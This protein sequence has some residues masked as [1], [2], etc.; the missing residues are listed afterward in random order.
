M[1]IIRLMVVG[2]VVLAAGVAHA[3]MFH[4][5]LSSGTAQFPGKTAAAFGQSVD[6]TDIDLSAGVPH[7][8][9]VN[10]FT[11]FITT[12]VF[13]YSPGASV[14]FTQTF[15][16]NDVPT[17][18]TRTL[19]L[20]QA[21]NDHCSLLQSLS[22]LRMTVDL[23]NSGRVTIDLST[24][25]TLAIHCTNGVPDGPVFTVIPGTT[26]SL[27]A[28]VLAAFT[29]YKVKPTKGTTKLAPFGP[30]SLND[31][32]GGGDYDVTALV[33]L[34]APA[35]VN[36]AGTFDPAT[37]LARYALKRRKAFGKF[38]KIVDLPLTS[39][40]GG[41]VVTVTKPESLLVPVNKS[42]TASPP[43]VP[44]P[45]V[46][47]VDHFLCYAAKTQK[48]RSDG[49]LAATLP[50]KMQLTAADQFETR[51]YDVKKLTRLCLPVDKSG[52]PAVL[53]T[54]DPVPI[55][56]ASI[57]NPASHLVC[58]QVKPAKVTI[59][60][61][62]CGPVDPKDKGTK[63]DPPPAKHQ[64]VSVVVNGQLGAASLDT[65]KEL[66]LCVPLAA[67]FGT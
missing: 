43:A 23:G 33:A 28:S 22:P 53:K 4:V 8:F 14:T 37:H 7:D 16:V 17:T 63:I 60:Q 30:L 50:K 40:C 11:N 12:D 52:S 39:E 1:R 62:S 61:T 64:P 66:E 45:Q 67:E 3:T 20:V 54:G 44:D 41:V 32:F 56:P 25:P 48:K 19:T 26:V 18:A 51:V 5:G 49:T 47:K 21:E 42:L 38:P 2:V 36:G 15:S 31:E 55:T 58:Y 65:V 6:P 34:D 57:R 59:P 24:P 35:S 9:P 46:S 29:S 13:P 10:Q 27:T